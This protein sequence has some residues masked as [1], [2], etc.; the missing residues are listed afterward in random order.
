[1]KA[2]NVGWKAGKTKLS[3]NFLWVKFMQRGLDSETRKQPEEQEKKILSDENP[4][5]DLPQ[6][7][8][9]VS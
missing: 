6:V 9:S 2:K 1:M 5:L 3:M 8:E 7:K 4:Y